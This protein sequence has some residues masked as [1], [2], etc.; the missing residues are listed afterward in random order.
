MDII[1]QFNFEGRRITN[2]E[3]ET[4]GIYGL[5]AAPGHQA[6]SCNVILANRATQ[7]FSK[8][9]GKIMEHYIKILLEKI[10]VI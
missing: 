2:L 1:Q 9:P 4:A 10:T 5:A 6:V 3:M 7:V 8:Q